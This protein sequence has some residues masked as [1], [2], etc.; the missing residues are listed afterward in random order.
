MTATLTPLAVQMLGEIPPFLRTDPDHVAV[1]YA[2]ARE[3]ERAEEAIST[4]REQ[5]VPSEATLLL[6]LWEMTVGAEVEPSIPEAERQKIV[7]AFLRALAANPSG[8]HWE[9]VVGLLAGSGWFYIDHI[10]GKGGTPAANEVRVFLPFAEGSFWFGTIKRL[11]QRVTPAHIKL[12]VE[13]AEG[14]LL[15]VAE[16]D[17]DLL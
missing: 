7:V 11:V 10:K 13:A 15:D 3:I 6:K 9:L 5:A 2:Y 8:L 14:F 17:H 16:L 12:N 4:M 1:A